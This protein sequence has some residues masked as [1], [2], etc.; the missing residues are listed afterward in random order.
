MTWQRAGIKHPHCAYSFKHGEDLYPYLAIF[1][2]D[3]SG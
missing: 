2:P 3:L 1:I